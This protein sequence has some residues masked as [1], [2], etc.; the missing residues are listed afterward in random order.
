MTDSIELF[1][2]GDVML[3]R[4]IDQILP[5]PVDP[6]LEEPYVRS[7]ETYLLLAERRH[8]TIPRPVGFDYIWGDA[9][10]VLRE[11]QPDARIINLETSITDNDDFWPKAV[12]Y[13][14]HPSNAPVLTAAGIDCCSLAN[15]HVL[16]FGRDGL[17]E[18]LATLGALDLHAPGAGLDA[19]SAAEPAILDLPGKGRV[20]VFA[21][22]ATSSGIPRAWAAGPS[23]PGVNLLPDLSAET[24]AAIAERVE[25]VRRAGDLLIASIHW[26]GNWG[27]EVSPDQRRFA[28]RLVGEA[29]FDVVHGHS[30]HHS[31]AIE[32]HRGKPILYGCGDFVT[33]YEGITGHEQFR[34]DV[35]VM[36][37]PRFDAASLGLTG[38][39]LVPLRMRRFRLE[40]APEE[41]IAWLQSVLNRESMRFDTGVE[42]VSD[43]MLALTW[44]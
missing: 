40:F 15:N 14:M 3:G 42:R 6:R 38:F 21:Y 2:C 23:E 36:Y 7:A 43:R 10:E 11:V 37:L 13:R 32:V 22:G 41:D 28:H 8:G 26:G 29:G 25:A 30:S 12:N 5:H 44:T 39:R 27:Y 4:A 18:T 31:K 19:A 17:I 33:D 35:A 24:I 1:L 9:F 34:G 16:D 20:L